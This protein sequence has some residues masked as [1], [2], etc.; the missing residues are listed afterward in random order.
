MHLYF[1]EAKESR[2]FPG[3][4]G[5]LPSAAVSAAE[6]IQRADSQETEKYGD[7]KQE[8]WETADSGHLGTESREWRRDISPY[9]YVMLESL[10]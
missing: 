10:P 6:Q 8:A 4:W 7:A 5:M 1:T 3:W 2:E 9:S